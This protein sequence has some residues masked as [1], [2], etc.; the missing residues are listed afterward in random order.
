MDRLSQASLFLAL[1][2]KASQAEQSQGQRLRRWP[3]PALCWGQ[4]TEHLAQAGGEPPRESTWQPVCT[5]FPTVSTE[6]KP[7]PEGGKE[8]SK[9]MSRSAFRTQVCP[10][11]HLFTPAKVE[12]P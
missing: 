11:E 1:K 8:L 3:R 9:R 7:A 4:S 5:E 10:G 6:H 2:G 12:T